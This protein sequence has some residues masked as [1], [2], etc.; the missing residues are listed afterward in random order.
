MEPSNLD[1]LSELCLVVGLYIVS[2]LLLEDISLMVTG[3]DTNM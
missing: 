3:Q 2:H 1:F